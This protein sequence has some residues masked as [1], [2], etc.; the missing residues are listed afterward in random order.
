MYKRL[1]NIIVQHPKLTMLFTWLT[2]LFIVSVIFYF[3]YPYSYNEPNFYAEDGSIFTKNVLEKGPILALITLFNGYLII[4]QYLLTD[5]AVGISYIV[6]HGFVSIP[7]AIALVSYVFWAFICTIPFIL[8]KKKLGLLPSI[9]LV[10]LLSIVP[11][12]GY[13]YATIGT[14]GNLKFAFFF[15]AALLIIYRNQEQ[16]KHI[17]YKTLLV[18]GFL[19]LCILTN[20]LVIALLPFGVWKYRNNIKKMLTRTGQIF[21]AFKFEF[22][23]LLVLLLISFLYVVIVYVHGIPKT[24]GYLDTPLKINTL[25]NI[26][27]RGS[28]YGILF[29]INSLMNSVLAVLLMALSLIIATISKNRLVLWFIGF[30]IFINVFGFVYNRPGVSD[31]FQTY[32]IWGGPGQFFYAGTMLFVFG[33]VYLTKDWFNSRGNI[34]RAIVTILVIIYIITSFASSGS[35]GVSYNTI[36]SH[37]PTI[38]S[39]V[40]RICAQGEKQDSSTI[41]I[42]PSD[43]WKLTLPH[44]TICSRVR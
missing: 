34:K 43:G 26:F 1:Q 28:I 20:I 8:F 33:L 18:D 30:A 21:S 36:I 6:G 39:E 14:I 4:G 35:Q 22:I 32:S 37:R 9:I 16:L 13:D 12:G 24:P 2:I 31:F 3:R 23:S 25:P 15:I 5:I 10:F 7:R 11:L 41:N 40:D 27:F 44:H 19:L 38:G 17:K 42:Y 29:P